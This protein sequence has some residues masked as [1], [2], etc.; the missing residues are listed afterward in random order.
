M[1]CFFVRSKQSIRQEVGKNRTFFSFFLVFFPFCRHTVTHR[2]WPTFHWFLYRRLRS[3]IYLV[4]RTG[5]I[6][7]SLLRLLC[8]FILAQFS[9]RCASSTFPRRCAMC[10]GNFFLFFFSVQFNFFGLHRTRLSLLAHCQNWPCA[11]RGLPGARANF[12]PGLMHT[13]EVP[14]CDSLTNGKH[15]CSRRARFSRH[16][17]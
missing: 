1:F 5:L 2:V 13:A 3:G 7:F 4:Q 6:F 8:T 14:P 17:F 11:Y 9:F 15:A 10:A 16:I 12:F